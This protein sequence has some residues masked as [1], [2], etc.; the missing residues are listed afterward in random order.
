MLEAD[1]RA[2]ASEGV[3]MAADSQPPMM[4]K[5]AENVP[6]FFFF[7]FRSGKHIMRCHV[8]DNETPSAPEMEK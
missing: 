1:T 5:N 4:L 6:C 3:I 8:Q 2:E 7:V